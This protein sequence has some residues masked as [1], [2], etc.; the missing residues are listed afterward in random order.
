MWNDLKNCILFFGKRFI[1]YVVMIYL[2]LVVFF[3]V[4]SAIDPILIVK[5]FSF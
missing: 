3:I 5:L 2:T 4:L 1:E